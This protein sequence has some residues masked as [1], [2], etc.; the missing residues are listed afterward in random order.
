M[1][2]WIENIPGAGK[3]CQ[4]NRHLPSIDIHAAHISKGI[5]LCLDP[6]FFRF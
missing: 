4:W 1:C 2:V 3:K 5:R 6:N